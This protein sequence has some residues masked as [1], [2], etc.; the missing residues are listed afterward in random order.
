MFFG[1]F[2]L[3]SE[4]EKTASAEEKMKMTGLIAGIVLMLLSGIVCVGCLRARALT[5]GRASFEESM[6]VFVPTAIL[7]VVASALTIVAASRFF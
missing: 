1:F 3:L 7:F 4:A 2:P 6:L 5:N